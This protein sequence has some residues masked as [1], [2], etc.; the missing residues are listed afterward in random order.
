[1][2]DKSKILKINSIHAIYLMEKNIIIIVLCME[3]AAYE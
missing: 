1:M 3:T 2:S